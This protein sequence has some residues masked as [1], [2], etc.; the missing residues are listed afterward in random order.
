MPLG[1]TRAVAQPLPQLT[2]KRGRMHRRGMHGRRRAS[3]S[4]ADSHRLPKP[5]CQGITLIERAFVDR[6]GVRGVAIE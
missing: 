5:G 6:E 1:Q 4:A 2:G 3:Q